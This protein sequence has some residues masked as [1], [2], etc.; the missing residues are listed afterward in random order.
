MDEKQKASK[1]QKIDEIKTVAVVEKVLA[2]VLSQCDGATDDDVCK[3]DGDKE[4]NSK[5]SVYRLC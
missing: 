3:S 4:A 2:T 5:E 1:S